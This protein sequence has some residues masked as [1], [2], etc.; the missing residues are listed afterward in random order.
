MKQYLLGIDLGSSSVKVNLTDAKSGS[1]IAAAAMPA[2]EMTIL[3]PHPGWAEQDPNTWWE[4]LKKATHQVLKE[5]G[6]PSSSI[7]AVGISYQM[8]GLVAV[9]QHLNVVRPSI[10][11]CDGR[12]VAIGDQASKDL[13]ESYTL[14]HLLNSPGNFTLSKLK[15]VKDNEPERFALIHKVML[16]GDYIAMKLTGEVT[17]T[18]PGLSEGIMWDFKKQGRAD[19]L[20]RYFDIDPELV[21]DVVPTF[22]VQG[23][24]TSQ[25]AGELGLAAGTPLCYRAG[26]QPNNAFSLKALRPGDVATTAGTS[27]VIYMVTDKPIADRQA[28]VNTFVHVNHEEKVPRLG[29]LLCVNG[30]GIMNSWLRKNIASGAMSY[31]AMNT[32]AAQIPIGSDQL[33]VLPFGNGAERMLENRDLGASFHGLNLNRHQPAHL[34]RAVQ[35]GIVFALGYGFEILRQLG[36]QSNVIR[37]GNANMF[38]S[39]V[40][41]Q[42]FSQVTGTELQLYDVDGAQGAARGAGLGLGYY[43][44]E[45]QAFQ[46]LTCLRTYTPQQGIKAEM[47]AAYERW[48]QML[49]KELDNTLSR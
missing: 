26:D 45:A 9:D 29:V 20:F 30:T 11:W 2:D 18:V 25:A 21:A 33:V 28:R 35:E 17:T 38:Q 7:I 49:N 47:D 16:P 31:E 8:H 32:L 46:N 23:R 37:A 48:K 40:F 10:I 44:D 6:V 24:L 4:H 39:E 1:T 5:A 41:C 34:C 22:S 27:G 3:C 19:E 13:G 36:A 14:S 12:A 42:T 15:W 43:A